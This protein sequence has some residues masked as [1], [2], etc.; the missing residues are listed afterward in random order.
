VVKGGY[1]RRGIGA[2]MGEMLGFFFYKGKKGKEGGRGERET[3]F[4]ISFLN[5]K[6]QCRHS[7][8]IPFCWWV[9]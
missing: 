3:I 8:A 1:L 4:F 5:A 7:P 6:M 2:G 9:R